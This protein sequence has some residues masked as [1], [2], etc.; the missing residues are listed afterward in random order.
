[1]RVLKLIPALALTSLL[2]QAASELPPVKPEIERAF[3]RLYNFDFNGAHAAA[4]RH[5]A[6]YPNDPF[7][8]TTR[9]SIYLFY[10]LD[11]LGVLEGEF[12]A[13]DDKIADKKQN[14]KPDPGI[15]EKLFAAVD[16]SRHDAEAILAQNPN[17]TNALFSMAISYGVTTDYMALIEKK[18]I[19]S[20]AHVKASTAWGNRLLKI[21]PN[22]YDAYLATGVTEYLIGSLPF[23]VRWFVRID[24]VKGDKNVG[25]AKVAKTADKGHYLKPFAKV[26]LAIAHL[27][28]KR[29][30]KSRELLAE[31]AREF[32]ENRLFRKELEKLTAK[33]QAGEIRDAS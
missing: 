23:F 27:R 30:T 6:T 16:R 33:L 1:M 22:F 21:A 3:N 13:D 10:E 14:L 26:L 5:I 17:D 12:F 7:G 20:L 15:R 24:D 19:R 31:L 2:A 11:R 28:E 25:I 9:A 32:P 8:Y 29:P 4:S 18:Q